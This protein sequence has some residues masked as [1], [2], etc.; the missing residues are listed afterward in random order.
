MSCNQLNGTNNSSV[1]CS[2]NFGRRWSEQRP[3]PHT[4]HVHANCLDKKSYSLRHLIP[5]LLVPEE[6][7]AIHDEA[8]TLV[9]AGWSLLITHLISSITLRQKVKYYLV[10]TI[11]LIT[12][13]HSLNLPLVLSSHRPVREINAPSPGFQ[14]PILLKSK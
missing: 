1:L 9:N 4:G 5:F 11:V 6:Y 10:F 8:E 7:V 14:L 2:H 13:S 12:S 3:P